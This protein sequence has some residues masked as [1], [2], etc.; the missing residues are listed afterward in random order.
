M[1]YNEL[2][3]NY[4]IYAKNRTDV[5]VYKLCTFIINNQSPTKQVKVPDAPRHVLLYKFI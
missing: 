2:I 4:V 5:Q 3:F 1:S